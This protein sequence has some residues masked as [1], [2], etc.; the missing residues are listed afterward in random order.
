MQLKCL[1]VLMAIKINKTWPLVSLNMMQLLE[2]YASG[3]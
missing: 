1:F 2:D 3:Y